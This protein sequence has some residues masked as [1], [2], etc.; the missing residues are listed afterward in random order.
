MLGTVD[1]A[2]YD[3][4]W[5][6]KLAEGKKDYPLP[7]YAPWTAVY[8]GKFKNQNKNTNRS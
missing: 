2:K 6:A 1:M 8:E 4:E 5:Y 3:A 7:L